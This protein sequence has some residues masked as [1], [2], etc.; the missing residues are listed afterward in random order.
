MCVQ[1]PSA[2]K[3]QSKDTQQLTA[4]VKQEG[5]F[6]GLP[7]QPAHSLAQ[8]PIPAAEQQRVYDRQL[9]PPPVPQHRAAASYQQQPGHTQRHHASAA[10]VPP[11]GPP[12]AY[13]HAVPAQQHYQSGVQQYP[14]NSPDGGAAYPPLGYIAGWPNGGMPGASM[15]YGQQAA[16]Y[17]GQ[18][19][20][21]SPYPGPPPLPLQGHAM[22]AGDNQRGYAAASWQHGQAAGSQAPQ[23]YASM[24]M[25]MLQQQ[26]Q[27]QKVQPV[28][29]VQQASSVL[30]A[31]LAL[32]PELLSSLKSLAPALQQLQQPGT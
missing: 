6:A 16:A 22:P 20:H 4:E 26:Q 5:S 17:P 10:P 12:S 27:Q 25:P 11:P 9:P 18:T 19:S 24:A 1:D 8:A 28:S 2:A 7:Q 13:Q 29:S 32:S 15:Q 3:P 14:M 31:G 21:G 23:Y 30:G